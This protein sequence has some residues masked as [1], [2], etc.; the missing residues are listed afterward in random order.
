MWMEEDTCWR[1][2]HA[3]MEEG[4]CIHVRV[5][6]CFVGKYVHVCLPSV[7]DSVRGL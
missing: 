4:T 6:H 5:V 2:I 7:R 3:C 1:R